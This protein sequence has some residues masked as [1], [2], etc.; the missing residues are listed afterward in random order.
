MFLLPKTIKMKKKSSSDMR[1]HHVGLDLNTTLLQ[2]TRTRERVRKNFI[3]LA[4]ANLT[5]LRLKPLDCPEGHTFR[6][7]TEGVVVPYAGAWP[8]SEQEASVLDNPSPPYNSESIPRN[9]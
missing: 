1:Y 2:Q 8:R 7:E 6:L 5:K 9:P 3:G 4:N